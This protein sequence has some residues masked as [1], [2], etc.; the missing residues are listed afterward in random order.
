M[1]RDILTY[2]K[3]W[4]RNF[5]H[6]YA[7]LVVFFPYFFSVPTLLRTF[8]TPWKNLVVKEKSVL[9]RFSFNFISI[10]IG[11]VMRSC[12]LL[13]Y[14]LLQIIFILLFPL[15][16]IGITIIL[17]VYLVFHFAE[18]SPKV[19]KQKYVNWFVARHVL[20]EKNKPFV[21]RWAGLLYDNVYVKKPWWSLSQLF[22]YP[23]LGRDWATGFTPNLDLYTQDLTSSYQAHTRNLIDRTKEIDQIERSLA[24]SRQANILIVGDEGVGKHTIVDALAKKMYEGNINHLLI[25]NRI[26]K[27]DME[28]IL[29]KFIDQEQ[30][31]EFFDQ[32]FR[33]ADEAKNIILLIDSIGHYITPTEGRI[34]I[35]P[36]LSKFL[37]SENIQ[38]IGITTPYEYQKYIHSHEDLVRSFQ[39]I[40]VFEVSKED[41]QSILLSHVLSYENRY[42]LVIPYE[43]VQAVIEK[44]DFFITEI[45]FPEKAIQLLDDACIFTRQKTEAKI[46]TPD[47]IDRVLS[48][49]THI[50]TTISIDLKSKLVNLEALLTPY[51]LQQ[52]HA[53]K[54]VSSVLRRSYLLIGKRKKP[55]ASFLFL[56]PTGVGKTQTAQALNH[57]L[58]GNDGSLLRFDMS[59]YQSSFDIP[60]LIGSEEQHS[61][62]LLVQA[63]RQ[64]PHAVLLLDE[65]EKA[66]HNLLNIFLSIL[67]EGYFVDGFG[68]RVDCKHLIIIATSNAG[69]DIIF[70]NGMHSEHFIDTLIEHHYFS[71]ELLNRFDG[72]IPFNELNTEDMLLIGKQIS[73]RLSEEMKQTQ[74]ITVVVSDVYLSSLIS[75]MTDKRFGVRYLERTLRNKMED[76]LAKQILEGSI[77]PGDTYIIQ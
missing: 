50:T 28:Q 22:S 44:S 64:H 56:G 46:V 69:S 30:R 60:K 61:P 17:P 1:I 59:E 16:L 2:I 72:I 10:V 63:I 62:G 13:F 53:I 27:L 54:N 55:M 21:E 77:K 29:S 7:N 52:D 45:P 37:N 12:L 3:N 49:K 31:S 38:F 32:L 74:N 67:D 33:E 47:I 36:S 71:P 18:E 20:D 58:F 6:A 68:K 4:Y 24:R 48:E 14:I 76:D 65:V 34:D 39:K 8:F 75:S 19:K 70:K 25:Y 15:L 42:S 43:T 23:P 73:T 66:D 40:D 9:D 26:L 51:V 57:V 5:F 35:T 11:A 41:A